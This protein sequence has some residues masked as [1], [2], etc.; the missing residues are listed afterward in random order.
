VD[1]TTHNPITDPERLKQMDYEGK[2]R[3]VCAKLQTRF[4]EYRPETGSW[5]F[6]VHHFSKY[7]LYDSDEE[8]MPVSDVKKFRPTMSLHQQQDNHQKKEQE[9]KTDQQLLSKE[10]SHGLSDG[11]LSNDI[12]PHP[13]GLGPVL[14]EE[15]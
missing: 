4:L 13:R 3:R 8:D 14:L 7:G 6:K 9:H 12:G 10:I 5:V 11:L 1:K 2:L 15:D